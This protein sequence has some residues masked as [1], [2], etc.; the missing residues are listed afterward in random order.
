[1]KFI[2]SFN[3]F[4]T[5]EKTLKQRREEILKKI[6]TIEDNIDKSNIVVDIDNQAETSVD[7]DTSVEVGQLQLQ[8]ENLKTEL[9]WLEKKIGILS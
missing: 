6:S 4:L 5:E 7:L 2:Q 8:L 1:M 3:N 9:V